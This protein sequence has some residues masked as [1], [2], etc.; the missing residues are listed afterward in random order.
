M[1]SGT[2]TMSIASAAPQVETFTAYGTP[3]TGDNLYVTL[4]A[5]NIGNH[6]RDI[7]SAVY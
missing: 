6:Y 4:S 1:V 2:E 3:A 7:Y 5:P